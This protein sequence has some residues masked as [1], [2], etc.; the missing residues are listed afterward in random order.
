MTTAADELL[1]RSQR[2]VKVY[3]LNEENAWEDNGTGHVAYH[4]SDD[5]KT[6]SLV[7][8]SETDGIA[9]NTFL[10][11]RCQL[12]DYFNMHASSEVKCEGN[13]SEV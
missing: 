5:G 8:R 13:I 1:G 10:W 4:S 7:V 2:R 3:I 9:A 6:T 11:H 12:C